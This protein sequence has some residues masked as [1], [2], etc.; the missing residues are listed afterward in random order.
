[1]G[2]PRC[3]PFPKVVYYRKVA[4]T[5][6]GKGTPLQGLR[7]RSPGLLKA[8]V[9]KVGRFDFARFFKT[10]G[11]LIRKV[12]KKH[13][14][15]HTNSVHKT[16]LPELGT[17]PFDTLQSN[18]EDGDHERAIERPRIKNNYQ[19]T[20]FEKHLKSKNNRMKPEKRQPLEMRI[21]NRIGN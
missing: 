19:K 5:K 12:K 15:K 17:R 9:I 20:K 7:A 11:P 16:R 1:M 14:T 8:R 18:E 13:K 3:G 4:R 6:P 21:G 2:A 10:S